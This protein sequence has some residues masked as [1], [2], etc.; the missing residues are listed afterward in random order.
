M[1]RLSWTLVGAVLS[2]MACESPEAQRTRGGGRGA[3]QLNR[4]PVVKMHEGS[5]QYWKTPKRIETDAPPLDPAR[6]AREM[7]RGR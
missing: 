4:P 3:D 5:D 1:R 6:Q 2:H 7:S